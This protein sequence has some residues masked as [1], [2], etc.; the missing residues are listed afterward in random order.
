[1]KI[2][3]PYRCPECGDLFAH[4]KVCPGCGVKT[5]KDKGGGK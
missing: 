2:L 3:C 1:M 5:V 4:A